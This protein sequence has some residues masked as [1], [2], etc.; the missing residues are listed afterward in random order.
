MPSFLLH[1]SAVERLA[2]TGANLPS[3]MA[4]A[5]AEDLEYARFGA[6]VPDLPWFEGLRG[7][8]S[9]LMGEPQ[10]PY[11]AR[12]LHEKAPVTVG[13]KL[14]ELVSSG[15]LVGRHAG[16]A[17]V[18]GYFTHLCL[19]RALHPLV[20]RL[21]EIHR[22]REETPEEA[23]RRVEWTQALFYVREMHGRDLVGTSFIRSKLQLSK[24]RLPTRGIGR[25]LYE[26][27]RL[28]MQETLGEAP[29]KEQVDSWVRGAFLHAAMLSTRLGRSRATPVYSLLAMRELYRGEGLDFP[30]EVERAVSDTRVVLT[31]VFRFMERGSFT[32]RSRQRFFEEFPEGAVARFA[33]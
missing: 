32:L 24:S 15:A 12:L 21:V 8:L 30:A 3:P 25:G 29:P 14:A 19:D 1:S 7:A 28:S 4:R 9:V 26:L 11:F 5:L 16:L 2:E 27:V 31:Q 18:C 22:R 20:D 10:A 13:L 33:A 23:H 17:V 6:L